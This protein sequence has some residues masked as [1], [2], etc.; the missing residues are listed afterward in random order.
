MCNESDA[1]SNAFKCLY[2][3]CFYSVSHKITY[4]FIFHYNSRYFLVDF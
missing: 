2:W 3:I 4:H 1:G